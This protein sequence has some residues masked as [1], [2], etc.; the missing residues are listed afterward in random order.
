ME[1]SACANNDLQWIGP[2]PALV[3]KEDFKLRITQRIFVE[4]LFLSL[5]MAAGEQISDLDVR[6][7]MRAFCTVLVGRFY[8][9]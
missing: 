5:L 2:G 3:F 8:F 6:S 7:D 9:V 1:C 4:R